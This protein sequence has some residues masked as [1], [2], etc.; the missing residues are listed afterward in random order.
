MWLRRSAF[1]SLGA[2]CWSLRSSRSLSWDRRCHPHAGGGARARRSA[3]ICF[4][5]R[6]HSKSKN[7]GSR[8]RGRK[9]PLHNGRSRAARRRSADR[10][11]HLG[12]HGDFR[13][14]SASS[15]SCRLQ[16]RCTPTGK[17][18][19]TA[20]DAAEALRPLAGRF[21][22]LLFALGIIG[23]GLL[24][25][26]ALAGSAAYAI[27]ETFGWKSS[28][29]LRQRGARLLSGDRRTTLPGRSAQ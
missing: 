19:G 2:R 21:A 15:L 18:I 25:I 14:S 6:R 1:M 17:P 26:P 4:S 20:A 8:K 29:G 5:G 7:A 27:A 9:A 28:L 13:T 16:R 3:L 11:R 10:D 12:R 22:F 23:T 24:A